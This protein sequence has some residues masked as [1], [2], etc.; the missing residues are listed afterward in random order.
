[1]GVR[2]WEF[3]PGRGHLVGTRVERL[4]TRW[5]PSYYISRR[6]AGATSAFASDLKTFVLFVG[7]PRSGHTLV[8]EL[9]NAHPDVVISNELDALQFVA[10]G[11][12]RRQ[13]L[14]LIA[15]HDERFVEGGARW[16]GYD[17]SV[18]GQHQGR[19]ARPLV[20]GDKHG[21]ATV[22]RLERDPQ[23]L[24]RLTELVELP[25]RLVHVVR[26]PRDNIATLV[27]RGGRRVE[28]A[29]EFFF[30]TCATIDRIADDAPGGLSRVHLEDLVA[31]PHR[32]LCALTRDIGVEAPDEYLR[33]CASVVADA[34]N[35]TRT[36]ISWPPAAT[37]RIDERI[38]EHR[39]LLRYGSR[40]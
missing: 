28:D 4:Y 16:T 17:Y 37:R 27:R 20:I 30:D 18:P 33:A 19:T 31:D 23:L 6:R 10:A 14:W 32:V 26:D 22:T 24:D 11:F 2:Q 15:D 39:W 5:S 1:M 8:A 9:L 34:P 38:P 35:R 21:A 7:H 3:R 25:V 40:P 36:S 12:T 29:V 13:L